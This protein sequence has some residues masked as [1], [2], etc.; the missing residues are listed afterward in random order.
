MPMNWP[1]PPAFDN[2]LPFLLAD[3]SAVY[4]SSLSV[5][6]LSRQ[7]STHRG[8][9][10]ITELDSWKTSHLWSHTA[11]TLSLSLSLFSFFFFFFSCPHYSLFRDFLLKYLAPFTNEV[12][13]GSLPLSHLAKVMQQLHFNFYYIY[14]R[15]WFD[16]IK[17]A[18]LTDLPPIFLSFCIHL[19]WWA[20][21]E[22]YKHA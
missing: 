1:S 22:V 2:F 16:R 13:C 3:K 6:Y 17:K 18:K 19:S 21:T 20:Q 11:G 9:K 15:I 5:H 8:A 10:A 14:L 7:R 4:S 12:P